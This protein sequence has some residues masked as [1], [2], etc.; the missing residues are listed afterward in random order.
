MNH[1]AIED[2]RTRAR[3]AELNLMTYKILGIGASGTIYSA[4]GVLRGTSEEGTYAVKV[5]TKSNTESIRR[6]IEVSNM[7]KESP[8]K[9]A[10]R[11]FHA[12]LIDD[13]HGLVIME[14][15]DTDLAT[16]LEEKR[17]LSEYEAKEI[18]V[19]ILDAICALNERGYMHRDV[20]LGN[21]LMK[22]VGDGWV[23]RLGDFGEIRTFDKQEQGINNFTVIG[24]AGFAALEV[25]SGNY[26]EKVDMWSLGI[27]MFR[28]LYGHMPFNCGSVEEYKECLEIYARSG[29]KGRLFDEKVNV[30]KE[31]LEFLQ[32]LM[33]PN[34]ETRW[35]CAKARTSKFIAQI[36]TIWYVE[37]GPLPSFRRLVLTRKDIGTQK[38]LADITWEDL[39]GVVASKID[40]EGGKKCGN[41]LVVTKDGRCMDSDQKV[42]STGVFSRPIEALLLFEGDDSMR[43]MFSFERLEAEEEERYNAVVRRAEELKK[44]AKMFEN[45]MNLG[46]IKQLLDALSIHAAEEFAALFRLAESCREGDV[47]SRAAWAAFAYVVS[48]DLNPGLAKFVD[49]AA[50]FKS[51]K[52]LSMMTFFPLGRSRLPLDAFLDDY[53]VKDV[54]G[55]AKEV[56]QKISVLREEV[57]KISQMEGSKILL[58]RSK[59][60]I[61]IKEKEKEKEEEEEEEKEEKRCM[62]EEE[63]FR[64]T[65]ECVE[66]LKGLSERMKSTIVMA[67][68]WRLGETWNSFISECVAL[69]RVKG[70]AREI[71]KGGELISKSEVM[72]CYEMYEKQVARLLG[73][74]E[75]CIAA[76]YKP[77]E[78][79]TI[80]YLKRDCDNLKRRNEELKK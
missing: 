53:G 41:A 26:T 39:A 37:S 12:E 28:M 45:N 21:I 73:E 3:V 18:I 13:Y 31:C 17:F 19:P 72:E 59:K 7:L 24:T 66:D 29:E 35:S 47:M 22:R 58:A 74:V 1:Y 36:I 44:T 20:K 11:V 38:G 62:S 67:L 70:M 49:N 25:M 61:K 43:K 63:I 4:K 54:V 34:E 9:E 65:Q 5:I 75:G 14:C 71:A 40:S 16:Y 77:S 76:P 56:T 79:D 51:I 27:V 33:D 2:E 32:G 23:T 50:N 78:E 55:K 64:K 6:E 60:T 8:I 42:D 80:K 46:R 52:G 48:E 69:R 57:L 30:S 68:K 15:M 10:V